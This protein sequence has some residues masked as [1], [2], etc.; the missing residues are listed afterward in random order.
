MAVPPDEVQLY[1]NFAVRL[2][3]ELRSI[4]IP[5]DAILWH[6]TNGPALLAIVDS[7]SIFSTHISCL[8]DTSELRYGSRLVR[9]AMASLRTTFEKGSPEHT[10]L[11]GALS[12]FQENPEFPAQA[13]VPQF[14]TCLSEEK[15]DLSQWR[16][17]AGGE[18]GYAIGFRAADLR[19]CR[20]SVLA[21]INYDNALH[22]RLAQKVA[23]TM[24]QF[25]LE[26]IRKYS[27]ADPIAWG[28]RVLRSLGESTHIRRPVR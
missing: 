20:N 6:Y 26:G 1:M 4:D 16:A 7:M 12:H 2:T 8:N 23:E 3:G 14:V 17:Y 19:G 5:P 27:P 28:G 10:F 15:D 13:V 11:D 22:L 9:E 24:V 25:F 18:N 21:R